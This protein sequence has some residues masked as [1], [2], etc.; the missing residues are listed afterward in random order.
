MKNEFT[1][2][3]Y[4]CKYRKELDWSAH[5]KCTKAPRPKV[6]GNKHGIRS[7]WFYFPVNFDPVWL[8]ECDS[9]ESNQEESK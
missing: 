4:E 2:K 1:N 8:E 3:C 6:K 9:F 7:G 5:S